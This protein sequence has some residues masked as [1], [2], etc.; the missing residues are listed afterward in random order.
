MIAIMGQV[1]DSSMLHGVALTG[2][3]AEEMSGDPN[4]A[5]SAGYGRSRNL[6]NR[7]I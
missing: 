6:F 3:R 5:S 4:A 7:A 2:L 1:K